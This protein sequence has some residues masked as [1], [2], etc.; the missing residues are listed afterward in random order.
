MPPEVVPPEV[1]PEA[2]PGVVSPEVVPPEAW[3]GV[4]PPEDAAS[5]AAEEAAC[6]AACVLTNT[7]KDVYDV[8]G[9]DY[10]H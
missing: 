10:T 1:P 6:L 3:P 4:V 8:A 9:N 2:W 5:V 7:V